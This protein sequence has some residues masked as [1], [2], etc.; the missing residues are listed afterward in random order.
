MSKS[1]IVACSVLG[2]IISI[3][4]FIW[5]LNVSREI[6]NLKFDVLVLK[7]QNTSL[8]NEAVKDSREA[9]IVFAKHI[10]DIYMILQRDT[11]LSVDGNIYVNGKKSIEKGLQLKEN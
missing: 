8:R 3:L 6:D 2:T 1:E 9:Y 10:N 4:L 5:A 7:K 11:R